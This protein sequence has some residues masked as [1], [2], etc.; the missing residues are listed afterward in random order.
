MVMDSEVAQGLPTSNIEMEPL[1]F[2]MHDQD[3]I[4]SPNTTPILL[5]QG[6][7]LL[8]GATTPSYPPPYGPQHIEP[9][10]A[11][12]AVNA[13]LQTCMSSTY[14]TSFVFSP[15]S[16]VRPADVMLESFNNAGLDPEAMR[17]STMRSM[18][19]GI[20]TE[21]TYGA[22]ID[23]MGG[24]NNGEE[25]NADCE[26]L[27]DE[28]EDEGTDG[29]YH[30]DDDDDDDEDSNGP[31]YGGSAATWKGKTRKDE[32]R[33]CPQYTGAEYLVTPAKD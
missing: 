1:C 7:N 33:S 16:T 20:G 9:Y 17:G 10:Y 26:D 3:C 12:N 13:Y 14:P 11:N 15:A 8:G 5:S 32:P 19:H 23:E 30:D 27:D 18:T 29:D 25:F 31:D 6:S 22:A 21:S 28:E 2:D 24:E 4:N